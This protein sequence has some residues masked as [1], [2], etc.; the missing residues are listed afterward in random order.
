MTHFFFVPTSACLK[1]EHVPPWICLKCN[2]RL[3]TPVCSSC[4]GHRRVF[5]ASLRQEDVT[6][7]SRPGRI[8][9]FLVANHVPR[10]VAWWCPTCLLASEQLC[11]FGCS[12]TKL[13]PLY[14]LRFV[15]NDPYIP[16][17]QSEE[18][19]FV[20]QSRFFAS[21]PLPWLCRC[22][23]TVTSQTCVCKTSVSAVGMCKCSPVMG[24]Q[25]VT[26]LNT[27]RRDHCKTCQQIPR[28]LFPV[29]APTATSMSWIKQSKL[30]PPCLPLWTVPS[31][32]FF[33]GSCHQM[34]TENFCHP[35]QCVRISHY[36]DV[37]FQP[38]VHY[39]KTL[40][41]RDKEEEKR[42]SKR[43]RSETKNDGVQAPWL[44]DQEMDDIMLEI[45]MLE[46]Q[47]QQSQQSQRTEEKYP[48]PVP[49]PVPVPDLKPRTRDMGYPSY[50]DKKQDR[51]DEFYYE[52]V[53]HEFKPWT[54]TSCKFLNPRNKL[55]AQIGWGATR[56]VCGN[57][58]VEREGVWI[59]PRSCASRNVL[60]PFDTKYNQDFSDF[61]KAPPRKQCCKCK[62]IPGIR[63]TVE[64]VYPLGIDIDLWTENYIRDG[65]RN[66]GAV[67]WKP[68]PNLGLSLED[69]S[70][71]TQ[72]A[73]QRKV[74]LHCVGEDLWNQSLNKPRTLRFSSSEWFHLLITLQV[75]QCLDEVALWTILHSR[76]DKSLWCERGKKARVAVSFWPQLSRYYALNP[77]K[78]LLWMITL[79]H[80]NNPEMMH[81]CD[82][83]DSYLAL[84]G[85]HTFDRHWISWMVALTQD[86]ETSKFQDGILKMG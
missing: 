8:T 35:K 20:S 2:I 27:K 41:K 56:H 57:C 72:R 37:R 38:V 15:E 44:H 73:L 71:E 76:I 32:W 36:W 80:S 22:G 74:W 78:T 63:E 39:K 4:G 40:S 83:I 5:F 18:R 12:K 1:E 28:I 77:E 51:S 3:T 26:D 85:Y 29:V 50:R 59:C 45:A 34:G 46:S 10:G 67:A 6:S 81:C 64:V 55:P 58:N 47:S 69:P 9:C 42:E 82:I 65:Q 21:Q 61:P 31:P 54:C 52:K 60:V 79:A 70:R 24:M 75:E 13:L 7:V 19:P 33:C 30:L 84:V 48:V 62:A 23:Q 11:C 53:E 14:E 86:F 17:L 66:L 43:Q 49:V 25:P 68:N 16:E